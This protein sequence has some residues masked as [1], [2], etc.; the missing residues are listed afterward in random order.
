M[1]ESS[2]ARTAN[3]LGALSLAVHE[4]LRAATEGTDPLAGSEPATLVTLAH[5]PGQSIEALRRTLAITHSGAVRLVDRLERA[6]LVARAPGGPGRTLAIA[7]TRSG[8]AAAAGVLA[9]RQAVLDEIVE[10][11]PSDEQAALAR[12]AE[13]VLAS[14]TEDRQS[15]FHLCRLCDEAVCVRGAYC[16]V[17]RAIR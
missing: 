15:G 2:S 11:L 7:L 16:P 17:D 12:V 9:R 6:G 13:R 3:L 14:L 10:S 1:T 5:Y 4:R 8:R